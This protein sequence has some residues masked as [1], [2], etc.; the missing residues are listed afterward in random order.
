MLVGRGHQRAF[1]KER[2]GRRDIVESNDLDAIQFTSSAQG[3]N[4]TQCH[5]VIGTE[6]GLQFGMAGHHSG[7]D[8]IGLCLFPT[9]G[10]AGNDSHTGAIHGIFKTQ[11]TL[12]G[13]VRRRYAFHD[14]NGIA[15]LELGGQIV[16]YYFR[17]GPVIRP[18]KGHRHPLLGEHGFVKLIVDVYDNDPFVLGTL[19]NG[20]EGLGIGG[21]DNDGID[22]TGHHLLHQLDLT[23][24]IEFILDALGHELI[25]RRV[26]GLMGTGTVFHGLEKFIG[27]GLHNQGDDGFVGRWS[28]GTIGL[29]C[30]LTAA[31]S[32]KCASCGQHPTENNTSFHGLSSPGNPIDNN[33]WHSTGFMHH[34]SPFH[35][36]RYV[37]HDTAVPL[38]ILGSCKRS[39]TMLTTLILQTVLAA[40]SVTTD[41]E[42]PEFQRHVINAEAGTGLAITVADVNKDGQ[43]DIIGVSDKDVAWY[44]NPSWERHLMADTIRNSN[45]CIAPQDIDGDGIPEFALGADWQP[46]NTK[47]GG[48]LFLLSHQGDVKQPWN[49]TTLVETEPTLHRIRWADLDGDKKAELV[50]APL[51][52]LNPGPDGTEAGVKL[53]ALFPGDSPLTAPWREEVISTDQH[54]MHN[55]WAWRDEGEKRDTLYTASLAGITGYNRQRNGHY[56]A[57]LVVDADGKSVVPDGAGEIKVALSE[58]TNARQ[59]PLRL[60][61]TIE[62]WHGHQAVLY[63]PERKGKGFQRVV[64]DDSL[65][66][67]HA[68]WFA[69][70]DRDN[71]QEILVGFREGAGPNNLPGL[72]I[73]DLDIAED[74][75][76]VTGTKHV[77]DDGGMATEDALSVDLNGD[78]WPDIVAFG[79]ATHN[80]IYYENL[81]NS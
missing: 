52:G 80:I 61:A 4:R 71:V 57:S 8:L 12:N 39:D 54:I 58:N 48:A 40:S 30:R 65:K 10:L 73:Y 55:V 32:D 13:I 25:V 75:W 62:P 46:G 49:V 72:N 18:H 2:L 51:K 34:R 28:G 38:C 7:Y 41:F 1:F 43:P 37:A 16:P 35:R 9:G 11:F 59:K 14:G 33:D 56:E 44:E 15:R 36:T 81:G 70:F 24:N 68:I 69:D 23:V 5:A 66:G 42:F 21:R 31:T 63:S 20:N 26:L 78:G 47:T 22:A 74:T 17:T 45:V 79:R 53:Y 50:V 77:I 3:R 67:G 6:D 27:K 19:A 29:R 60:M 76:A 64:L